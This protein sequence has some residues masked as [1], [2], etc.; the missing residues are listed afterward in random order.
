MAT[1]AL[2]EWLRA[3]SWLWAGLAAG[4]L[5]LTAILRRSSWFLLLPVAT[6]ILLL[7]S[8]RTLDR[9]AHHWSGP[10]GERERRI[11][12][13]SSRLNADL[14]TARLRADSLAVRGLGF[15]TIPREEGFDA[16]ASLFR[17]GAL[18]SGLMV[19]EPVG[20]P[21]VWAGRFR[22]WPSPMGDSVSARLTPF[23][24]VLEVRRH[25]GIGR[26]AIGAVLLA[27][28]PVVPDADQSVAA[29]FRE[30]TEV[31]LRILSSEAAPDISDVFDYEMPTTAGP[32]V[33]FSVQFIPPEQG[34]AIARAR[35]TV[36]FRI[37]W[38]LLLTIGGALLVVPAGLGRLMVLLFPLVLVFRSPLG[39]S[40]GHPRLVRP[41]GLPKPAARTGV[42]FRRGA[43]AD[44]L[45]ASPARP[46][47]PPLAAPP[48][49]RAPRRRRSCSRCP[50]WWP[51]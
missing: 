28:D 35:E 44:R 38:L 23:Y 1:V 40:L 11:Q 16:A 8:Q 45:G 41:L 33:L 10:Q 2:G 18:E 3:P 15:G 17:G 14:T 39:D 20:S 47:D 37:S 51:G 13:A 7:L 32:R 31:G 46:A 25:D 34:A 5:L 9:L 29:R 42:V 27:A 30:Q 21:R 6:A 49:G 12:R 4:L 48:V 43:G 36:S 50:S 26:T 24:A 22:L 19:F